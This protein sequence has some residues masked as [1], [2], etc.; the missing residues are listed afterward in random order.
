MCTRRRLGAALAGVLLAGAVSSLGAN[1]KEADTLGEAFTAEGFYAALRWRA[2]IVDQD[3]FE[4]DAVAIPLR[5]RVGYESRRFAGFS[6]KVEYDYIFDFG[7]D[8]YNEGGGNTPERERYPTVADPAGGDLNQAY[9]QWRSR[10]GTQLRAGR[11]K[12]VY[13]NARFIG[14]VVW[15]QNEQTYDAFGFERLDLGGFD[16]RAAYL[17][18]VH[19][20][21]GKDVPAGEN[22]LDS[23]IFNLGYGFSGAGKLV[24]YLYD[25]DNRDVAGFS[26]TTAG[27]RW[28]GE[29]FGAGD[30]WNYTL[31]FARQEDAANNPV[32]YDANYWRGDLSVTWGKPTVYAGYESLGGDDTRPGAAFRT[33]LATLHAFNGWADK[34]LTTPDAGLVDAFLGV[35]GPLGAWQWN[36]LWHD[37]SAESGG[38]D[39]GTELDGSLSRR[40]DNGLGLLFKAAN[41]QSDSPLHGDTL[42]LWAQ[43]SYAF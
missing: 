12:I 14:D 32:R 31:E 21:F 40:F 1:E 29:A 43:A 25:I 7:L 27:I 20:I 2:E 9:L 33:P 5:A 13:D 41:F 28:V 10:S 6:L 36:V 24:A 39:F 35:K 16:L 22:D 15:R 37:F 18:K 3:P 34:F 4:S 26:T 30:A 17:D 11:Q 8:T 23:W 19:R 38:V 42:K